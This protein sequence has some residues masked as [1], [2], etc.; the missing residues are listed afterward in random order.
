M[1]IWQE[2]KPNHRRVAKWLVV[3]L[4]RDGNGWPKLQEVTWA[5][6][7]SQWQVS[8]SE[9]GKAEDE[10]MLFMWKFKNEETILHISNSSPQTFGE[11]TLCCNDILYPEPARVQRCKNWTFCKTNLKAPP[12]MHTDHVLFCPSLLSGLVLFFLLLLGF[13]FVA[14]SHYGAQAGLESASSIPRL[15]AWTTVPDFCP[16]FLKCCLWCFKVSFQ[17]PKV[18]NQQSLKYWFRNIYLYS[19]NEKMRERERERERAVILERSILLM[20][21]AV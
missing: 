21:F 15:Q 20:Q 19:K 10:R 8:Q 16:C 9:L 4:C 14:G 1:Y 11:V 3:C 12:V 5:T 13:C 18:G 2:E 17:L 7:Q 6:S